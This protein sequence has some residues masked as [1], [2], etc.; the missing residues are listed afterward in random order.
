MENLCENDAR[1]SDA[2]M[3]ENDAKM[4]PKGSR[5]REKCAKNTCKKRCRNLTPKR[6]TRRGGGGEVGGAL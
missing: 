3:M 1:K 6:D 5:N 2:K 4:E